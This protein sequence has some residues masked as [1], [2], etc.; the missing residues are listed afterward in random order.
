MAQGE[1]FGLI[2]RQVLLGPGFVRRLAAGQARDAEERWMLGQERSVRQSYVRE[3]VDGDGDPER[4][5]QVWML[6]QSRPVRE[7]YIREVLEADAEASGA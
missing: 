6:R 5:A 4:L 7:S 2:A 1:R 3:V